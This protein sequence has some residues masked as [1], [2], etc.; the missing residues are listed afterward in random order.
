VV[1]PEKMEVT[2]MEIFTILVMTSQHFSIWYSLYQIGKLRNQESSDVPIIH[3]YDVV[4]ARHYDRKYQGWLKQFAAE[5]EEAYTELEIL[6]EVHT[7]QAQRCRILTNLYDP[8]NEETKLLL[9]RYCQRFCDTPFEDIVDHLTDTHIR[10]DHYNS[11]IL[12]LR[13]TRH[14]NLTQRRKP[15]PVRM[16]VTS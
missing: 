7:D 9:V 6:G 4:I 16:C 3:Y 8:T 1:A 12:P 14:S 5:Y 2:K 10:D 11:L 15:S 13:H